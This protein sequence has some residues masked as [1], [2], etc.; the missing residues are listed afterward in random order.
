LSFPLHGITLALDFPNRGEKL[1]RLFERLDALVAEAGGRLY[2]AKDGR[3]PG[4][5][6]RAGYPGWRAFSEWIDPHFSSS[7]WRRVMEES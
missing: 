5:L 3:M 6:F 1:H 7:F 2:P 4:A